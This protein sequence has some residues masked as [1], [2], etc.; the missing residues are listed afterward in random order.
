MANTWIIAVD[1]QIASLVEQGRAIG[2]SVT[3]VTV[4]GTPVAGVDKVI[5]VALPEGVPAEAAA[6]A[7]AGDLPPTSPPSGFSPAPSRPN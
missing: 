6:P 1:P 4:G 3:A 2:G 7:V 5:D